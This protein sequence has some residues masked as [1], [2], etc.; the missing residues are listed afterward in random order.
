[1]FVL[2]F[3]DS[4][5]CEINDCKPARGYKTV[6][7]TLYAHNMGRFDGLFLLNAL[8]GE[9]KYKINT[10]FKDNTLVK[11]QI[12]DLN[13]NNSIKILD[14]YLMLPSSLDKLLKAYN[15]DI[16]KGVLPYRFIN[17]DTLFYEGSK[18]EFKYYEINKEEYDLIPAN[19]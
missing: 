7:Y 15:C 19:N 1:M 12:K 10:F 9:S 2:R 17:K 18:P 6:E 11:L 13:T 8:C 5:F 14:S 4:L 16:F 3:I